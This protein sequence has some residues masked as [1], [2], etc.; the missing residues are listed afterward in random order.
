MKLNTNEWGDFR[1]DE[2]FPVLENGKANQGMLEDGDDCFY[3]GAKKDNN[4][5]MI[6]CAYD[7]SLMQK[8]NCIIFIC[9]GQGS[10]GFAN[11]MDVD[12]I[13]TTDI[14]AGYNENLNQ[15]NGLFIATILCQERPKY[16][17]G[18]KWKTHL[19]DTLIKLPKT[20][21]GKPD[22]V[23]MEEYVK[24]LRY[25]PLTTKQTSVIKP[26]DVQKWKFFYLKD[27]CQISMGNK[28]DY[29]V[30]TTEDPV[31][32][33]VGRSA[34]NQGVAGKVDRIEN[35]TPYKAGCISVALGGSLGSAYVQTEDFYTSQNVAVLEFESDISVHTKLFI[36]TSIM[37]EC[38]YK[39]FPFG[40]ELNT[41]IRTDFGFALPIQ[42]DE[43]GS[44]I[45]D[46]HKRFSAEGYIPDWAFMEEYVHSLPYGDRI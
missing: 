17:F 45:I 15:Y 41:H 13:G 16:S 14:V 12:F 19:R 20:D 10:V 35:V 26:L 25:K 36:T 7:E 42:I 2:L 6:H 24:S 44:A 43:S 1:I 46:K 18:R 21:T 22:W 30:M 27:L 40:R 11:Y 3:I 4:G 31:I 23:Y 28:L 9:N 38:K 8:G 32:N 34:D 5:V 39:Y 29:T 37:N 33:F